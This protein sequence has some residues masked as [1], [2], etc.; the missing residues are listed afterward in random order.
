[1]DAAQ[2]ELLDEVLSLPGQAQSALAVL[3]VLDD[4]EAS[5]DDVGR[6]LQADQALSTRAVYIAN[7]S[8]YGRVSKVAGP[9]EAAAV[10]GFDT[11]RSLAAGVAFGL[12][13]SAGSAL[14]KAYTDHATATA[15]A[16]SI[17][18]E[19]LR[20]SVG[21]AFSIGLLHDLGSALLAIRRPDE[22]AETRDDSLRTGLGLEQLELARFGIHHGTLGALA[23]R[24]TR[25]PP[26]YVEAILAHH[27][28][29]E[30]DDPV[31]GR[32]LVVANAVA[33]RID[34][35]WPH[36]HQESLEDL[37]HLVGMEPQEA[38]ELVRSCTRAIP[39]LGMIG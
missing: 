28:E 1:M 26:E 39:E 27:R 19:R 31:M 38:D 16:A 13:D 12:F 30:L 5:A 7:S 3:R 29:P 6:R 34:E 37:M 9:A 14:P 33:H 35:K 11:V 20:E 17:L 2:K 10:I 36:D 22:A 21:D 32:I 23:L 25:F 8:F 15:A 24:A 4:P 18:A